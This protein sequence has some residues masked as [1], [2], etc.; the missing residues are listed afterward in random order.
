MFKQISHQVKRA[1][2]KQINFWKAMI[3]IVFMAGFASALILTVSNDWHSKVIGATVIIN[4]ASVTYKDTAGKSYTGQSNQVQTSIIQ[5]P[6]VN[7]SIQVDPIGKNVGA[8][9]NLKIFVY[10]ANT[11]INPF[12]QLTKALST[13][14]IDVD[15]TTLASGTYDIK[16]VTPYHLITWLRGKA[17]VKGSNLNLKET[18]LAPK[19]GNLQDADDVVNSLDWQVMSVKWGTTDVV[20][21][22]NKD[23][24]VNS[25]DW[26]IMNKN[27][28]AVGA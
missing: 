7:I 24:A 18:V 4:Q 12:L 28:L 14:V 6:T 23:G 21:D 26:G 2:E 16:I 13:G 10:Q 27:W 11:T 15:A 9:T 1:H 8:A 5:A 25:L 20:A 17:F 3:V 22:I 19:A